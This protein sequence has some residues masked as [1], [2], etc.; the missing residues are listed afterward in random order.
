MAS[1]YSDDEEITLQLPKLKY[2]E[3]PGKRGGT[4]Y[5]TEDNHLYRSATYSWWF[6]LTTSCQLWNSFRFNRNL[7]DDRKF[8]YCFHVRITK[9][10]TVT[11]KCNAS[12]ILHSSTEEIELQKAHNHSPDLSLLQKFKIR[13]KILHAAEVTTKPL[14]MVFKDVTRNEEGAMLVGYPA[15]TRLVKIFFRWQLVVN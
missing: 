9:D 12:G 6:S 13:A 11:E 5:Q 3:V 8:V 14:N 1:A 15:M 10:A 7:S 2:E 4:L